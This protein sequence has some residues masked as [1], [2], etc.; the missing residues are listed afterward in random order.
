[1]NI[2][3]DAKRA[4]FNNTGL[5]NYSRNTL[6][7]LSTFYP[8]NAYYL[9]VPKKKHT[10]NFNLP[11]AKLIYPDSFTGQVFSSY[12]RSFLITGQIAKQQLDIYH[13]L[14]NEL[15]FGIEKIKSKK[16]VTIH[17]L[18]FLRYPE[19]YKP[20]DRKMYQRKFLYAST[21]ADLVI[22]VSEQT[23]RDIIEFFGISPD[24]IKVVYQGCNPVFFKEKK[25]EILEKAKKDYFLPEKFILYVGT[26]EERKNLLLLIKALNEHKISIPLIAIG[27]KTEYFSKIDTYINS[28]SADFKNQIRFIDNIP[29]EMLQAFYK[30]AHVFVYPSIFEGFGIPIL[31]SLASGTP[32]IT[33]KGSCFAEAGGSGA[34]Y[35]D[36]KNSDEL[37]QELIRVLN[38]TD[39]YNDLKLKGLQHAENFKEEQIASHLINTYK[40]ILHGII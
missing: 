21:V 3:F 40:N 14:S 29:N 25:S 39:L 9:Y 15:P 12:W 13:G 35:I 1:M 32:V 33:S 19:L 4:F 17:D 16:V 22:A 7:Q 5:G 6:K 30:L 26:I 37:A 36:S 2:G 10:V 11:N 20:F 18:I 23:K 38:D 8:E 24:K 31:E 34:L 28:C 27:R